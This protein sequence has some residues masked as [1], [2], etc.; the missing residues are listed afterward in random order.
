MKS[1]TFKHEIQKIVR[2]WFP[3]ESF[4]YNEA[5][6]DIEALVE[7]TLPLEEELDR[8]SVV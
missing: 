2:S 1:L 3:G 4:G 7:K 5:V 6:A 8:K